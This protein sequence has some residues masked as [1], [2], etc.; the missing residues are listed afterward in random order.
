VRGSEDQARPKDGRTFADLT[1]RGMPEVR[2][3]C[4]ARQA[5]YAEAKDGNVPVLPASE[6]QCERAARENDRYKLSMERVVRIECGGCDGK[7]YERH[8]HRQTVERA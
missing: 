4:M 5:K 7:H 3:Q 1:E 8:G 6:G 2:E